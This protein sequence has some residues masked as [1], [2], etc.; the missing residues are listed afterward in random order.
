MMDAKKTAHIK[1]L[2]KRY[3]KKWLAMPAV[4]AV[5]IGL[6]KDGNSGI[7]ISVEKNNAAL[8]NEIPRSLEGVGIEIRV[9]GI[10]KALD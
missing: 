10:F 5:G 2:K 6:L 4:Q 1:S 3:E 7:I 8:Q 9:S